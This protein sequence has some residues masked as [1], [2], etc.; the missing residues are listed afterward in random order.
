MS[1][2][3]NY[4]RVKSAVLK[5]YEMVPEAC[6]QICSGL[7]KRSTQ[8][9]T[10]LARELELCLTRWCNA[11]AVESKEDVV[12]LLVLEQFRNTLPSQTAIYIAE[13]KVST[14]AEAAVLADEYELIHKSCFDV[15]RKMNA[16]VKM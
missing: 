13:R 8:T 7:R 16:S 2:A 12:N 1:W 15:G 10:E 4:E 6:R 3:E 9:H 14:A 5:A 11:S